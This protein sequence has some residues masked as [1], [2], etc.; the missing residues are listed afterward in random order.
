MRPRCIEEM[1]AG[2]A[3]AERAQQVCR[4][5][6]RVDPREP[7]RADALRAKSREQ[8]LQASSAILDERAQRHELHI[9]G[10]RTIQIEK[11]GL[12]AFVGRDSESC[13]L[14]LPRREGLDRTLP[15][16]QRIGLSEE[17]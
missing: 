7:K 6:R 10:A 13:D 1:A 2:G 4:V 9:R 3:E 11:A 17:A 14:V 12:D 5:L 15:A 8:L 16:R